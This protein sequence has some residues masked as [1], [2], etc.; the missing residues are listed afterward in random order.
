[1]AFSDPLTYSV[2][3]NQSPKIPLE[4]IGITKSIDVVGVVDTGFTGFLQI[5]L[6]VGFEAN[7][8][9]F[10]FRPTQLADGRRIRNLECWGQ[11]RFGGKELK[12]LISLSESSEACLV[13]MQ[14]LQKLGTDFV[15]SPTRKL[16]IFPQPEATSP[17]VTTPD[18]DASDTEQK[19][20]TV[21]VAK[22]SPR[23]QPKKVA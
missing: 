17:P 21:A 20:E 15:F 16:A 8:I 7:L 22:P 1:M 11:V 18:A 6:T 12:G 9:L 14:F 3:E 19:A 13:G 23:Y 4:I 5:P 2:T 10:G